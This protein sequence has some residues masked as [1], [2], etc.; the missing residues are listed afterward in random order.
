MKKNLLFAVLHDRGSN[1]NM[2]KG[3]RRQAMIKGNIVFGQPPPAYA[4]WER[5][6]LAGWVRSVNPDGIFLPISCTEFDKIV[7]M[8]LPGIVHRDLAK[9]Q[10]VDIPAHMPVVLGDGYAMGKMA[11]EHKYSCSER[12]SK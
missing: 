10:Q 12:T 8:G 1:R 7:N 4:R 2:I 3:I 6:T 11:A 5:F 9:K